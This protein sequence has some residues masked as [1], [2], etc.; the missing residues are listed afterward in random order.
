MVD[1]DG[2]LADTTHR[3]HHIERRAGRPPGRD[4][5]RQFF[6]AAGADPVI[7]A[8]RALLRWLPEEVTIVLLSAR[9]GWIFDTTV[10]GLEQ[11]EVP[12]HLLVLRGEGPVGPA[13]AFKR[14][15]VRTLADAGFRIEACLDDDPAVV[16]AY[17]ADGVPVLPVAMEVPGPR[18]R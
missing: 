2:V 10:G 1:L 8:T 6:A 13:A 3:Q 15:V 5:W 16:A 4:G 7:P 11:H 14:D 12:W 17:R 9:P 18:A